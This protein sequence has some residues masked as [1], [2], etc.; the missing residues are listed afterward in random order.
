[1]RIDASITKRNSKHWSR[2]FVKTSSNRQLIYRDSWMIGLSGCRTVPFSVLPK[3]RV[4]LLIDAAVQY[5]LHGQKVF[6]AVEPIALAVMLAEQAATKPCC[7][8]ALIDSG[9]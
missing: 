3:R 2:S 9:R 6:S 7:G 8:A 1:M 5:Y 4:G